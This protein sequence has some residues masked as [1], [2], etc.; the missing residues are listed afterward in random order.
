MMSKWFAILGV[1]LIL[2]CQESKEVMPPL[3]KEQMVNILSD[4]RVIDEVVNRY[5]LEQRDSM[6]HLLFD[7]LF[8]IH[9]LDST[10]YLQ[11]MQ[12]LQEH[13]SEHHKIEQRVHTRLK[14]Y[15]DDI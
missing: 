9:H 13:P 15:L 12:Y 7:S 8:A 2:G 3:K 4:V 5:N 1:M 6:G 11:L 14:E 10:S